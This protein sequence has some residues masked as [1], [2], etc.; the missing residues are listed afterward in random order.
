ME[1]WCAL[2]TAV[3]EIDR[4]HLLAHTRV[5]RDRVDRRAASTFAIDMRRQHTLLEVR[6]DD[7]IVITQ[8]R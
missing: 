4:Q 3:I 6:E 8:V 7:S 2:D 5:R 1:A